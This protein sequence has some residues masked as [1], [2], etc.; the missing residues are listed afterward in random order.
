[1]KTI[2]YDFETEKKLIEL[3]GYNLLE[4]DNSNRMLIV[5]K[6]DNQVGF[7]QYKKLFKKNIKKNLP[8]TYGYNFVID[9]PTI[10]CNIYRKNIDKIE[11]SSDNN[12]TYEFQIKR[13][14]DERI[15]LY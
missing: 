15:W 9:S 4:P 5:D 3:F 14:N 6:D 11:E 2:E 10:S 7:I 13:E 1:M 8:A 12:F